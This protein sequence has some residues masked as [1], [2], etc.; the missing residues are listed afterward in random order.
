MVTSET[1][2]QLAATDDGAIARW[3]AARLAMRRA[4][5]ADELGAA[6]ERYAEAVARA[7]AELGIDP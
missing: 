2:E 6:L 5:T 3:A 1:L 7:R 4:R